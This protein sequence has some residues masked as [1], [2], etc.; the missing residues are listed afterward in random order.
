MLLSKLVSEHDRLSTKSNT[1]KKLIHDSCGLPTS[2]LGS[3]LPFL[4]VQSPTLIIAGLGQKQDQ[5]C[6]D[7]EK[8]AISQPKV[9]RAYKYKISTT[10]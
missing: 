5:D 1:A 10:N 3:T 2:T 7:C 6:S 9:I 4:E 8:T